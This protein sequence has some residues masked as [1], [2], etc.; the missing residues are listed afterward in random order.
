ML[1]TGWFF[2]AVEL[3]GSRS[4]GSCMQSRSRL[5]SYPLS[6]RAPKS[7]TR[8]LARAIVFCLWCSRQIV[9]S[10][11]R[12]RA[13]WSREPGWDRERGAA[14]HDAKPR[15]RT[16]YPGRDGTW[17]RQVRLDLD[18]DR[19]HYTTTKERERGS[20]SRFQSDS[21]ALA[22]SALVRRTSGR[23]KN[24]AKSPRVSGVKGVETQEL[25]EM[26]KCDEADVLFAG[27]P[28]VVFALME[29]GGASR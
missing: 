5:T 13:G 17:D 6:P 2:F 8:P 28:F 7:R 23:Y 24:G 18:L 27:R 22:M 12:A 25:G 1:S 20:N 16:G 10:F 15:N 11:F 21:V 14:V 26:L 3:F 19:L 29:A 4:A 9:C